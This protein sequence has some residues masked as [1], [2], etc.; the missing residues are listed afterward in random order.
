M[1]TEDLERAKKKKK[2]KKRKLKYLKQIPEKFS[3]KK[4]LPKS[5]FFKL[6]QPTKNARKKE[7]K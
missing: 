3:I 1:Q 2:K 4:T 5:H 6:P 7:R